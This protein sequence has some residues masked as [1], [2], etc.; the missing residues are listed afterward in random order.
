MTVR[1]VTADD[2]A[3][4]RD[5]RLAALADAPYAFNSRLADWNDGGEER[6][7]ARLTLPGSYNLVAFA[8]GRPV[9][10]VRGVPHDDGSSEL[11]SMWVSPE[12]RGR[13]VGDRLMSAVE[14]WATRSGYTTLKLAVFPDNAAAIALYLRHGYVD[15]GERG[16]LLRDGVT[17][18]LVLA[19]PLRAAPRD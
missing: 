19:K 14:E 3:V 6:W 1:Q 8:D 18:E 13:G 9:G 5:V 15:A 7:R 16:G 2:W 17:R 12:V 4:W 11:H 10:V